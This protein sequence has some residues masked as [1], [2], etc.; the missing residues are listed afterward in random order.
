MMTNMTLRGILMGENFTGKVDDIMN[1]VKKKLLPL[2]GIGLAL[3]GLR[4]AEKL[5]GFDPVTGLAVPTPAR[6]A[7]IAAVVLAGA[8]AVA[9]GW[10]YHQDKP[11]FEEHFAAPGKWKGALVLGGFLF[12]GG[13]LWLGG[14]AGAN[15]LGLAPMATA[16]LAALT[17]CGILVLTKRMGDE[18][19]DST[20]APLLPALFFAAF[21]ML[22]L[23]IPTGTDPVLARYWLP[24]LAAGMC[25]YA[26][27][28]LAGF[29]RGESRVRDF[30]I[31]ARLAVMLSIGAAAEPD[32]TYA[33]LFIGCAVVLSAFLALEKE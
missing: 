14:Q 12:I 7:L 19:A 18:E 28:Q 8:Y 6:Y 29:F 26:L 2:W 1:S 5:T 33:P 21:W 23:Y 10:K 24:I 31:V 16:G 20:V 32:V 17:G 30:A 13:G 4:L 3:F 9:A 22:S 11:A 25:A 27:A 15:H